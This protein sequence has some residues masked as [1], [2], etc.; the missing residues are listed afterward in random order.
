M[1]QKDHNLLCRPKK[2]DLCVRMN[3]CFLVL[4]MIVFMT[5]S[6]T[7]CLSGDSYQ[8]YMTAVDKTDQMTKGAKKIT[9]EVQSEFNQSYL[10]GLS[11]E[12]QYNLQQMNQ[13]QLDLETHFDQNK[14]QAIMEAYAYVGR[15]GMDFKIYQ[16]SEDNLLLKTP[17]SNSYYQ[18]DFF[19]GKSVNAPKNIDYQAFFKSLGREWN[20]MLVSDNIFAGEKSLITNEDGDVKATKF[21]IKP[22]KE[23]LSTFMEKLREA[24]IET[25]EL[26]KMFVFSKEE[27]NEADFQD[28]ANTLM[29]GMKIEKYEEYAYVD[30]DGYLIEESV[31]LTIR[32]NIME[33][34]VTVVNRQKITFKQT[35]WD[36]EKNQTL[37]F[38]ELSDATI[39]PFENFK[40]WSVNK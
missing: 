24:I 37:D 23:Q 31:N 22:T 14:N 12:E 40:D 1:N 26:L 19:S 32:F 7:G 20:K 9:V 28:L 27:M 25:P 29:N 39:E 3:R 30:V 18:M 5:I 15:M 11:A 16:Q 2:S 6:L 33:D 21:S 8:D 34:N 36:I 10:D 38:G 35:Y 17:F 13:F 4:I